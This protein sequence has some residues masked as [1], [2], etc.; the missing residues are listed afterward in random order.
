MRRREDDIEVEFHEIRLRVSTGLLWLRI[1]TNCWLWWAEYR[2]T[3]GSI[4]GCCG[5]LLLA[6]HIASH[7]STV[8]C[9]GKVVLVR[10]GKPIK[11]WKDHFTLWPLYHWERTPVPAER[12]ARWSPEPFRTFWRRQKFLAPAEIRTTDSAAR[13]PIPAP[14]TNSG[15]SKMRVVSVMYTYAWQRLNTRLAWLYSTAEQTKLP[16]VY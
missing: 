3:L 7:A 10:P 13:S 4:N 6:D 11:R 1:R 16:S 5:L 14:T 8:K 15:L 2:W 12:E 9:K